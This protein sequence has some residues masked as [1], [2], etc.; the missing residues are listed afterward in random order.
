M[1]AVSR[2]E[3]FLLEKDLKKS[4]K[5]TAAIEFNLPDSELSAAENTPAMNNPDN[6]G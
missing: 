3:S 2:S 1:I 4:S 6:P 5:I